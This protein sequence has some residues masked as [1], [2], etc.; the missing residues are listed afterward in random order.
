VYF[1]SIFVLPPKS[2]RYKNQPSFF[3]FLP[4]R[5]ETRENPAILG[6]ERLSKVPLKISLSP[7]HPLSKKLLI[8]D[9]AKFDAKGIFSLFTWL[10]FVTYVT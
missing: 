4:L 9:P 6:K 3:P 8:T 10:T 1:L 5:V 2:L 7:N